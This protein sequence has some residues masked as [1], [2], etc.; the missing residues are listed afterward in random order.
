MPHPRGYDAL[1]FLP[2]G[3]SFFRDRLP[4]ELRQPRAVSRDVHY[5][6]HAAEI[7]ARLAPEADA[8]MNSAAGSTIPQLR[9]PLR[10]AAAGLWD[11]GTVALLCAARQRRAPSQQSGIGNHAKSRTIVG[12]QTTVADLWFTQPTAATIGFAFSLDD[13]RQVHTP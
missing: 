12:K 1:R 13:F 7:D 2:A 3:G 4:G 10:R 6:G 8:S 5:A 9:E 11:R